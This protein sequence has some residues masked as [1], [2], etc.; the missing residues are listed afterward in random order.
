MNTNGIKIDFKKY[1]F[2]LFFYL[3]TL[4]LPPFPKISC[5]VGRFVVF[6]LLVTLVLGLLVA[7]GVVFLVVLVGLLVVVRTKV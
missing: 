3:S 2:I 5:N 6:G 7:A 1:I 4:L